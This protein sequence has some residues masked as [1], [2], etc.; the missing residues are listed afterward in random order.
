MT[1][2]PKTVL[3]VRVSTAEQ[4]SEHQVTQA[5]E[6]GYNIRDEYTIIDHGVSGVST[7]LEERDQGKR[8]F[9]LLQAG[10]T[11]VVRWVD[12]LG[13]NY[14]DVSAT[15]RKFLDKGV[16]IQTLTNSMKF[17]AH[18]DDPLQ[19]AARDAM[20]VFMSALAAA[21]ATALKEARDAGISHAKSGPDAKRKYRGRKP[22]YTRQMFELV[23]QLL[24]QQLGTSVIAKEA[25]LTRQVIL[26][27]KGNPAACEATLQRWGM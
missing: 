13:R 24:G 20:L 4:T 26:R 3:Y 12:R 17:D 27:I 2:K 16:T 8:L 11:L 21:N 23:Q 18:L 15:M 9:D 22:A 5:R 10:D 7:R 14:K 25:G 6:A 19:L 1:P